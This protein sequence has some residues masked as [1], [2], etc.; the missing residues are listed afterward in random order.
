[1]QRRIEIGACKHHIIHIVTHT[2][3]HN[4]VETAE[5][6]TRL[7]CDFLLRLCNGLDS[8]PKLKNLGAQYSA[9]T[10]ADNSVT[11]PTSLPAKRSAN[12]LQQC[13]RRPL[14]TR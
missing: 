12:T 5:H 11:S 1:M 6:V 9:A 3:T 4:I 8:C 7:E 13:A 10:L 14:D 2:Q